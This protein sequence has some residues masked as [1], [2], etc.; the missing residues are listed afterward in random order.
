M[1]VL[2]TAALA[3][4]RPGEEEGFI[5]TS[6]PSYFVRLGKLSSKVQE[7]ALEQSL[8]R[9]RKARDTTHTAVTQMT[10]T[11]DLLESARTA[12]A[13][14]NQ[15]LGG[16]PE[17][18]LQRWKEWKEGQPKEMVREATAEVDSAKDQGEVK[19]HKGLLRIYILN[20]RFTSVSLHSSW[21]REPCRW[22]EV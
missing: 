13:S 16:A 21:S 4:S 18:L 15:Q 3:E 7:R 11:L 12:L 1:C 10:S 5:V 14:A 22:F 19:K 2:L 9:A 6:N 17:Q 8:I 20:K